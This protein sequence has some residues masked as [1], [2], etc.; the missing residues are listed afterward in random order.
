AE[1]ERDNMEIEYSVGYELARK[2]FANTKITAFIAIN[3][4][5]AYGVI[6]AVRDAGLKVP[7]DYSVCGFDNIL[8]S[9]FT[10]VSLTT[11]EHYMWDKGHNAF[12]ILYAKMSGVASNRNI[13]RVEFKHQLIVRS[14]TAPPRR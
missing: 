6:D 11:V 10:G 12:D 7:E 5:V 1:M 9:R 2:C 3:D 13:T 4:M 14:S 8:P